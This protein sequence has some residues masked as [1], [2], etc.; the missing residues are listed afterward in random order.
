[1]VSVPMTRDHPCGP[2][3]SAGEGS[4]SASAGAVGGTGCLVLVSFFYWPRRSAG[5]ATVS[6]VSGRWVIA[7]LAGGLPAARS[8]PG[9]RILH[10]GADTATDADAHCL[11]AVRHRYISRLFYS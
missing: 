7:S 5:A 4:P 8:M 2:A 6:V 3:G 10:R 1:V 9:W 11:S